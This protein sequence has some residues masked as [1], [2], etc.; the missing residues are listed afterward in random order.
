MAD[1]TT[2]A[3]DRLDRALNTLERKIHELKLAPVV[4]DDDLF[5]L[6]A[7]PTARI[8]DERRIAELEAAGR[9]ASEALARAAAAVREALA[10]ADADEAA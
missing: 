5:A 4:P 3:R 10:E 2:A 6:P 9:E 1:A 7:P 8:E